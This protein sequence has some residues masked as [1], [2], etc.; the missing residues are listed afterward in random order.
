MVN[1]M[2]I[3]SIFKDGLSYSEYRNLVDKLVLEGKTTGPVQTTEKVEF[4]KLNVQ[5]MNRL[6]KTIQLPEHIRERI[7]EINKPMLWLLIAEGWCGD[8]AQ[9]IP[10]INKIAESAGDNIKLRIVLRDSY[11][12]LV[13]AYSNGSRSISL[14]LFIDPYTMEVFCTWGPRPLAAKEIARRWKE[15]NGKILHDDFEKELHLWYARDRGAAI[16]N[17]VV[18]QLTNCEKKMTGARL[19]II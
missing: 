19:A 17:E 3:E 9:V 8:S 18:G 12:G 2:N 4:T 11:P 7:R 13:E 16:M 5:R 1:N 6:D 15:S 14:L 10:V